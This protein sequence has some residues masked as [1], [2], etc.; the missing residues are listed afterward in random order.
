MSSLFRGSI[1]GLQSTIKIAFINGKSVEES[2][3]ERDEKRI[4]GMIS[5]EMQEARCWNHEN[6]T[7]N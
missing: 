5:T 4:A 7:E 2:N 6:M 3:D 1:Y